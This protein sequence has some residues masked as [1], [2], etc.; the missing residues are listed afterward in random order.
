M[1]TQI[2][3]SL[4]SWINT[5]VD[6]HP[7]SPTTAAAILAA[8]D[9][10]DHNGDGYRDFPGS[11]T[12]AEIDFVVRDDHT[13]GRKEAGDAMI[14]ELQ[15]LGFLVARWSAWGSVGARPWVMAGK[16]CTLY[17]GG[18]ILTRDPDFM[19]GIYHSSMYWHPGRPPNWQNL[20]DPSL[21]LALEG[22][23]YAPTRAAAMDATQE[24]QDIMANLAATVPLCAMSSPKAA[25]LRYTGGTD[26]VLNGDAEDIYRGKD[27]LGFANAFGTGVN[28]GQSFF[29]CNVAGYDLP[30]AGHPMVIRYGFKVP[31]LSTQNAI[32]SEW[33]WDNEVMGKCY[34]SLFAVNPYDLSEDLE[35]V[36]KNWQV[37][38]WDKG[39]GEKGTELIFNLNNDVRFH[40]GHVLTAEDIYFTF[41][42]LVQATEARDLPYPWYYSNLVDVNSVVIENYFRVRVRLNSLSFFALHWIGGNIILPAHI[43]KPLMF[44]PDKLLNTADDDTY[45]VEAFSP[46]KS[47]IGSGAFKV[48]PHSIDK[49]DNDYYVP[50][51]YVILDG[52]KPDEHSDYH[53]GA[54][55]PDGWYKIA[56]FN[57][58]GQLTIEK[59]NW[60]FHEVKAEEYTVIQD[61]AGQW[62]WYNPGPPESWVLGNEPTLP[63]NPPVGVNMEVDQ[64][65]AMTGIGNL[66][67]IFRK[68]ITYPATRIAKI[69]YLE[70]DTCK[71]T[72]AVWPW[73]KFVTS[74]LSAG[75]QPPID[76]QGDVDDDGDVDIVDATWLAV[77]YGLKAFVWPEVDITESD[78]ID[79][80]DSVQLTNDWTG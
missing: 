35:N 36:A 76:I 13:P 2:P 6:K 67:G 33:Y 9:I 38:A 71:V 29:D 53:Y 41:V 20:A 46:D 70:R 64:K 77:Q 30:E 47:M 57:K 80:S 10:V 63:P 61:T 60:H 4:G 31:E 1:Y 66:P 34:D 79:A 8:A 26:E 3:P 59:L 52:F 43:W 17:T 62:W 56:V 7:Y 78:T 55:K 14:V 68:H 69:V 11:T 5:G 24:A 49:V 15:N 50:Y 58:A 44:G 65:P 12:T 51:A 16:C 21:D 42:E 23:Q 54:Y 74:R 37:L 40:D 48:Y 18:W 72:G 22:I 28:T 25:R 73:N 39:G 27:W 75:G 45:N 32:Y 19:F